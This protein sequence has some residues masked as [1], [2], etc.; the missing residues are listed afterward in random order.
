[1][2][3]SSVRTSYSQAH[4][5]PRPLSTV[6]TDAR[7][8]STATEDDLLPNPRPISTTTT[9]ALPITVLQDDELSRVRRALGA[10]R[11]RPY[12]SAPPSST[13]W[14]PRTLPDGL[15]RDVVRAR[16]KAQYMYYFVSTMYNICIVLQLLLGASLTALGSTSAKHGLSI[17]ILAAAN[18]VNAGV[19]ALLH[20]SGLRELTSPPIWP[21]GFG[22]WDED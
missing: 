13:F 15:Y 9:N 22:Y 18:T 10:T 12:S 4:S 20:N 16:C 6:T 5:Q 3:K 11:P 21:L 7:P 8:F 2:E 19:V 1:M 14:P 17:V